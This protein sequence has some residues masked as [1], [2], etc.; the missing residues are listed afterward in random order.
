MGINTAFRANELLSIQ[1]KQVE[2]LKP[3]DII[4][5]KQSKT[6]KYRKVTINNAVFDVIQNLI[7]RRKLDKDDYLF[8]GKRGLLTVSSVS[9]MVK[10]WCK[11]VGLSGSYASH[12]LRKTWLRS[13]RSYIRA[14]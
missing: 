3:G 8:K 13:D 14:F 11:D 2:A 12:S 1:V 10:T 9:R 5:I 4:E 6:K 7:A